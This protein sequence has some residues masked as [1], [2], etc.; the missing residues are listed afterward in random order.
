LWVSFAKDAFVGLAVSDQMNEKLN[1]IV[2]NHF[3]HQMPYF[4]F[5]RKIL[6]ILDNLNKKAHRFVIEAHPF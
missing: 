3:S 2:K 5:V 6:P 1:D 4:L